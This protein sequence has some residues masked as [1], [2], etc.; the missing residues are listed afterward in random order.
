M[1]CREVGGGTVSASAEAARAMQ[2]GTGNI[3]LATT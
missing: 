1:G 2:N 3:R